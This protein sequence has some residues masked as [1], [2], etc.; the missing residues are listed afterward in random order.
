ML[1]VLKVL[2]WSVSSSFIRSN[3]FNKQYKIQIIMTNVS[4]VSAWMS[5]RL[6]VGKLSRYVASHPGQLSLAIPLSVG[7]GAMIVFGLT[8]YSSKQRRPIRKGRVLVPDLL[9]TTQMGLF[10]VTV[11]RRDKDD[12]SHIISVRSGLIASRTVYTLSHEE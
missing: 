11:P 1:L 6:P 10:T 4:M 3:K 5:D 7:I 9:L 2:V 8:E 12:V